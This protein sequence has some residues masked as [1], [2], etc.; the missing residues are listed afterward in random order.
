MKKILILA[1]F[2]LLLTAGAS[3]YEVSISAPEELQVGEPITVNGT[4]N[5]PAGISF[6][7]TLSHSEYLTVLKDTKTVIVQ[8]D[9]NFSVAFPTTGYPHGVYK[10]EVLP[11]SNFKY[12]GNSVTMRVVQLTDRSDEVVITTPLTQYM[13]GKLDV[14]GTAKNVGNKGIEIEVKS[15]DGTTVFGPEFITTSST[16][17]FSTELPITSAGNYTVNFTDE[18]GYIGAFNFY[19]RPLEGDLTS[20]GGADGNP[21]VT[22]PLKPVTS[23]IPSSTITS[24]TLVSS[25]D[26]PAYFTI[27][28][29]NG[30][31]RVYTSSGVDWIIEYIDDSGTRIKVNNKGQGNSEEI[32]INGTG[33]TRYFMVYPAK[34]SDK[35]DVTL[36]AENADDMKASSTMPPGFASAP[37]IATETTK[38]TDFPL[39]TVIFAIAVVLVIGPPKKQP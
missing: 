28:T 27:T 19:V 14:A 29:R 23:L 25:R 37:T 36:T 26:Q 24:A 22:T 9:K 20:N 31:V 16:G 15:P 21:G 32:I 39:W 38:K 17:T 8:N 7:I 18:K 10:V 13:S 3:A 1:I 11:I 33:N 30:P 35:A 2:L 6:D 4:S 34:Y 5:F 12:L